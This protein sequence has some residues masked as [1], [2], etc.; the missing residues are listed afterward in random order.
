MVLKLRPHF[1]GDLPP[2][3]DCRFPNVLEDQLALRALKI[4][5]SFT[6]MRPKGIDM[7]ESLDDEVLHG[8]LVNKLALGASRTGPT[9]G[10]THA[11][12]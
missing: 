4:V 2:R 10:Y 9:Y 5:V 3:L 12:L 6:D 8:L 11:P 7:V 1:H